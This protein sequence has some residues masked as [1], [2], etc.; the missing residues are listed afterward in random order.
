M[1]TLPISLCEN[2]GI[3]VDDSIRFYKN[4]DLHHT[5]GP[6]II[7]DN[8]NTQYWYKGVPHRLDGPA[9]D[10][11]DYKEWWVLGKQYNEKDFY[12]RLESLKCPEYFKHE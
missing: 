10:Y 7:F 1:K 11:E 2:E 5:D 4:G 8:G 12:F 6:A 9:V 3:R